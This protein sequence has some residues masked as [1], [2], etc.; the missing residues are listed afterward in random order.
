M[1]DKLKAKKVLLAVAAIAALVGAVAKFLADNLD[2][3]SF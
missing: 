3:L 2:S 1:L